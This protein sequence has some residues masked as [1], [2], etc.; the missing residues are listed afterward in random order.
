MVRVTVQDRGFLVDGEFPTCDGL[1]NNSKS[2]TCNGPT[3]AR[4][5]L[6]AYIQLMKLGHKLDVPNRLGSDQA[7]SGFKYWVTVRIIPIL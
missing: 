1:L 3:K 4:A 7:R 5:I 6:N 2:A